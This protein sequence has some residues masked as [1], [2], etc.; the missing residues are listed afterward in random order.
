MI[1]EKWDL[2]REELEKW[3]LQS[4]ERAK[5]AIAEGRFDNEIVPFGDATVDEPARDQL[6]KMRRCKPSS[7]AD[8]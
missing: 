7:R 5:A 1:A 3:A 4:H 6:E 8:A 2:S